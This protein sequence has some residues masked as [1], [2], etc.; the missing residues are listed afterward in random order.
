MCVC[1]CFVGDV[2]EALGDMGSAS[3]I[4]LNCETK[5]SF[6]LLLGEWWLVMEW[7]GWEV[8]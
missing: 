5:V 6:L 2:F 1:V 7:F 3:Q 4:L 8:V